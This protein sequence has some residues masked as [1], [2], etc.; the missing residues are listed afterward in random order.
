MSNLFKKKWYGIKTTEEEH[1]ESYVWWITNS[2]FD[3][4]MSFFAYA[5]TKG[6][7]AYH[8][9]PLAEAIRAYESIGYEC[10]ELEINEKEKK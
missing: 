3:S 6:N 4:W 2:E 8:A 9:L 10:I 7:A 1:R 5:T